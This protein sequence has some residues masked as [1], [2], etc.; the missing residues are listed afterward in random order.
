MNKPL[1]AYRSPRQL[2]M[3]PERSECC[4]DEMAE[5]RQ[6]A[7]EQAVLLIPGADEVDTEPASASG[8]HAGE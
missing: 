2:P 1:P 5:P 8:F 7:A 4:V 3:H 6:H